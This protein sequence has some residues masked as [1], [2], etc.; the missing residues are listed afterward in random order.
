MKMKEYKLHFQHIQIYKN[1]QE[2]QCSYSCKF[3]IG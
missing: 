1:S 3:S 2:I